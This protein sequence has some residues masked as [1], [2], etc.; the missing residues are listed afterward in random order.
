MDN[1]YIRFVETFKEDIFFNHQEILK[2]K[3][4]YI[5]VYNKCERK[6]NRYWVD[7][8]IFENMFTP[9]FEKAMSGFQFFYFSKR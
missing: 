2:N 9:L 1:I 7:G 3:N 5:E 8:C 4:K 6:F